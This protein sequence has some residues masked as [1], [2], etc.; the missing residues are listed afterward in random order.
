MKLEMI[1]EKEGYEVQERAGKFLLVDIVGA[2][3]DSEHSTMQELE[4]YVREHIEP[5]ALLD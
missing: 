2:F 3:I 5:G 1:L 4:A